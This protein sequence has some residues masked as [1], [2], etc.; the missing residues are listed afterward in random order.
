MKIIQFNSLLPRSISTMGIVMLHHLNLCMVLFVTEGP[1][2]GKYRVSV[3]KSVKLDL[4]DFVS[5]SPS[6]IKFTGAVVRRP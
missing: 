4:E 6:A 5:N 3:V 2:K 1:S